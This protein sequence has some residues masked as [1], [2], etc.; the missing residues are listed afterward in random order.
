MSVMS[1]GGEPT[2]TT[3]RSTVEWFRATGHWLS[4]SRSYYENKMHNLLGRLH[5][6]LDKIPEAQDLAHAHHHP[7]IASLA[8]EIGRIAG[9]RKDLRNISGLAE[10]VKR[11]PDAFV[12]Y[13]FAA[14]AHALSHERGASSLRNFGRRL[15]ETMLN[16]FAPSAPLK[17]PAPSKPADHGPITGG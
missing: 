17:P 8:Q 14:A 9:Y 6:L 11:C 13:V 10:A 15:V 4:D 5:D 3:W 7:H 16:P 1:I 12:G 2:K